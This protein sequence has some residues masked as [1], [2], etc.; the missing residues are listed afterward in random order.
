MTHF[1]LR[2]LLVLAVAFSAWPAGAQEGLR[3][4]LSEI[5]KTVAAIVKKR[6]QTNVS[7]GPFAGRFVPA[8]AGT[9]IKK[10]LAEELATEQIDINSKAS[11]ELSGRYVPLGEQENFGDSKEILGLQISVTISDAQGNPLAEINKNIKEQLEKTVTDRTVVAQLLGVTQ[12]DLG[13]NR[14][15]ERQGRDLKKQL[16]KPAVT[17]SGSQ[18]KASPDGQYA[19]E[20]QVLRDGNYEPLIPSD[21]DGLAFAE[22]KKTDVFAVNIINH[23]DFEAAFEL[24][25]DGCSNFAFFEKKG[26][27]HLIVPPKASYLLKGWQRNLKVS[28]EF[29]ITDYAKGA[30]QELGESPDDVGTITVSFSAA[31]D[32]KWN[33]KDPELSKLAPRPDDDQSQPRDINDI[34]AGRGKPVVS[35]V[36]VVPREIGRVRDI[37]SV[38]YRKPEAK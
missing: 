11:L 28:D 21:E 3:P 33:P 30:V 18:I 31:W 26:F 22:L 37:I 15:P 23:S 27:R 34:A 8:S 19:I 9:G 4:G 10:I 35:P 7:F 24:T 25:I 20:L 12:P 17:L 2:G 29:V 5:S 36:V 14:T 1:S 16:D 13:G 6:G 38:R 32:P